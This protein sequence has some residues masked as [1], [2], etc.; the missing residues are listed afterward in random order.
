MTLILCYL[1]NDELLSDKNAAQHLKAKAPWLTILNCQ[2][3]RRSFS[4]P[5][6]K[7]VTLIEAS[8]I[9]DELHQGEYANHARGRSLAN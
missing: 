5:Y 8:Y 1:T 2:L 6:L 4:G 3:L 7:C 9:L